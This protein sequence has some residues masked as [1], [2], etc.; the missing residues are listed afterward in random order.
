M[1]FYPDGYHRGLDAKLNATH[2]GTEMI[3]EIYV[4]R[5]ALVSF[6]HEVAQDFREESRSRDLW[7]DPFH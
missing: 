4:P 2:K 1:S 6:M 5:P 3:T 7:H